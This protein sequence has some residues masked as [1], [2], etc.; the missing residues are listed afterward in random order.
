MVITSE[1]CR[2]HSTYDGIMAGQVDGDE[3][4]VGNLIIKEHLEHNPMHKGLEPSVVFE[5]AREFYDD[6]K[7]DT[8]CHV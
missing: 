8:V 3:Y 7:G 6:T 4:V 5:I 2:L 1:L